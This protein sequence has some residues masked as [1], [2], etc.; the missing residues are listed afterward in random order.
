MLLSLCVVGG[1]LLLMSRYR[2]WLVFAAGGAVF[3]GAVQAMMQLVIRFLPDELT[4]LAGVLSFLIVTGFIFW[5]VVQ[6]ENVPASDV[7]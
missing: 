7:R 3:A 1:V 5:L 4:V 6:P 2:I